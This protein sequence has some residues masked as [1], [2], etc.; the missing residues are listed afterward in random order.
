[1]R[2][3]HLS[4]TGVSPAPVSPMADRLPSA[5][6][7]VLPF[8]SDH[9]RSGAGAR[10]RRRSRWTVGPAPPPQAG[11]APSRTS[12]RPAPPGPRPRCARCARCAGCSAIG[13]G[14][15]A[16]IAGRRARRSRP[17][18]R[19][20]PQVP[21]GADGAS[22][23]VVAACLDGSTSSPV[24]PAVT[25]PADHRCAIFRAMA[26]PPPDATPTHFESSSASAAPAPGCCRRISSPSGA[27][28]RAGLAVRAGLRPGRTVPLLPSRALLFSET[29]S[30]HRRGVHRR[31]AAGGLC[32]HTG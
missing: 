15:I 3:F 31:R 18:A 5:R 17:R 27:A 4:G 16:A 11:G 22:L 25:A 14:R 7:R 21:P 24:G 6:D 26:P 30:G 10:Q 20:R 2:H 9:C 23:V 1:L 12:S 13:D 32:L 19:C 8:G 29:T 28:T